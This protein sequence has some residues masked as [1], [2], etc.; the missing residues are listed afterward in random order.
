M[1]GMLIVLETSYLLLALIPSPP[2]KLSNITTTLEQLRTS[3]SDA[4]SP[5]VF[6]ENHTS[7]AL[8]LLHPDLA[9]HPYITSN[10]LHSTGWVQFLN[11][12][13]D[14]YKEIDELK[15]TQLDDNYM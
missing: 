12:V 3:K 11:D 7:V 2:P 10:P 6:M 5:R 8:A 4:V 1:Y 15:R 9:A 13:S 14:K